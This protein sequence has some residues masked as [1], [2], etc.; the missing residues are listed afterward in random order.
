MMRVVACLL[1]AA[2]LAAGAPLAA[3]RDTASIP[4]GI[5]LG[6]IYQP[7]YRPSVAV[8][9][10]EG[11]VAVAD[12]LRAVLARDLDYSDR[13]VLA[14][15]PA[16][17]ASGPVQYRPLNDLGVVFLV[18]GEVAEEPGGGTRWR[19]AVHDVVY[20]F[21]KE[22]RTFR[23]PPPS[24]PDFRLAV[25]AVA[26][27]VVRWMTG[28]PGGAASRIAVVRRLRDGRSELLVVDSDGEDERRVLVSEE[29]VLSPAWS[30][31]GKRLAYVVGGA[32]GWRIYERELET[33]A[34]RLVAG[35][36]GTM[37][38]TPA[39][40]PDGRRIAFAMEAGGG[41]E[42][43][44]Y[45]VAQ[46]CCLRRIARSPRDDLSPTFSPDGRRI[47]FN[48]NRLGTPHIFVM[49]AEGGQPTLLSPYA[50]DEPGY[51]TSPDWSPAGSLVAFHGRSRGGRFQIMVADAARPLAAPVV[52]LTQEGENEDPS[53]APDGRH[54]V[55]TSVRPEGGGLYVID[56]VTG[57]ERRLRA[58]AGFA[59]PDWS[60]VL[61]RATSL[62][63]EVP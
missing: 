56:T 55:Y 43:Y 3:Q 45:D 25:H 20:G 15:L 8:R 40:A 54:L 1:A 28:Q 42:L 23:L 11:G 58:G 10:F 57:R 37:A 26:D 12:S 39:Y 19:V 6:L 18:T 48:S 35:R 63:V 14:E 9:A 5:R 7:A 30:P 62:A 51:Y 50:Y 44:E 17:L 52:Q 29:R 41:L 49:P 61:L 46:G 32:G 31:D 2:A 22:A 38:I 24:S 47:A 53:W 16:S 36:P 59:V 27:E 21:V 13:F 4:K 33:G 60:P 34:T